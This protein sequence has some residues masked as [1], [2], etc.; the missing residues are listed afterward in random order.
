M[1]MDI[2]TINNLSYLD[3]KNLSLKFKSNEMSLILGSNDY[4]FKICSLD[5]FLPNIITLNGNILNNKNNYLKDIGIVK[6][7][8]ENSFYY[9]KVFDELLFCLLNRG[10]LRN[11]A[12]KMI[13]DVL[14]EFELS[15][16][17][18]KNT[19]DLDIYE[20][21]KLLVVMGV[22]HNPNVLLMDNPL[23]ILPKEDAIKI[24]KILKKKCH[25]GLSIVYFTNNLNYGYYSN[26]IILFN[27]NQY[28]GEYHYQDLYDNDKIFY[29]N[30]IEIPFIV[31]LNI[32]L[33]MY[34]II[35]K[36]YDD[37]KALVDNIWD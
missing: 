24:I 16:I 32:K 27:K 37:I 23:D 12:I 25:D 1:V 36:N 17:H 11:I 4:L 22:I 8:N 5:I 3:I 9:K 30:N 7:I 14:N 15:Y 34:N 19:S 20:K 28:V 6:R 21:Q 33:R 13:D 26:K 18:D 2:F 31:D 35:D 29:D 10:Y